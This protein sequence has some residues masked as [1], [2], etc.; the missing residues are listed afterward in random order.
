M[1]AHLF[2]RRKVLQ[3]GALKDVIEKAISAELGPNPKI[4]VAYPH[5]PSPGVRD[6]VKLDTESLRPIVNFNDVGFSVQASSSVPGRYE[7]VNIAFG[8]PTQGGV[9]SIYVYDKQSFRC[10]EMI[11]ACLGLEQTE[12][13]AEPE[14]DFEALEARVAALEKMAKEAGNNPKCFLSFKFDDP[15][16]VAQVNRVKRL[17]AAAHIEFLTGEQFE[18]RRIE[19]KVR[20]R[21]RAD[22]DFLIA[23]ISK[24]GASAWIRDEIVDAD[25]RDLW[26]I[27]LLEEGATFERG[28]F[29]T[30]EY[31]RYSGAIEKTF[32]ELL[33]G[34]NFIRADISTGDSRKD[35]TADQPL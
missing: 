10:V 18:P 1:E 25:S 30:L 3:I 34:I 21:L 24:R 6:S 11:A 2:Y 9:F 5:T 33:E 16:T 22:V 4:N 7:Y 14:E 31:I 23:V 13:V 28:I 19:D 29:G 26:I 12:P 17:L 8:N 20:A 32:P 15:E 35:R 27:I